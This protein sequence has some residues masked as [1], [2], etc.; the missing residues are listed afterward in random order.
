MYYRSPTTISSCKISEFN[1]NN[2]VRVE[3][4]SVY[5]QKNMD[6]VTEL[7]QYTDLT[8]V[9]IVII[10]D[11]ENNIPIKPVEQYS[12][13]HVYGDTEYTRLFREISADKLNDLEDKCYE[14]KVRP[15]ENFVKLNKKIKVHTL[16]IE[17]GI[18]LRSM[19]LSS[20]VSS[21][22]AKTLS[23]PWYADYR[24][25]EHFEGNEL[26]VRCDGIVD[27]TRVFEYKQLKHLTL[28]KADSICFSSLDEC[29]LISVSVGGNT[30]SS[31]V[32]LK[33]KVSENFENYKRKRFAKTKPVMS[34]QD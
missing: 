6:E 30:N 14:L 31:I 5:N 26:V 7:A 16:H 24:C 22:D 15:C 34:G 2:V 18:Y 33:A 28:D 19:D 21:F 29:D 17:V 3:S 9:Q 20:L 32:E 12:P 1:H 27:I 13:I 8:D 25:M 4:L 10:G 23:I 11:F